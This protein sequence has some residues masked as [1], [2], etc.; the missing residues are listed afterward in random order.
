[1]NDVADA[2]VNG[3]EATVVARMK[4]DVD[5]KSCLVDPH[6][7]RLNPPLRHRQILRTLG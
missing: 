4:K 1:M 2:E 3:S 5:S 7:V 6:Q